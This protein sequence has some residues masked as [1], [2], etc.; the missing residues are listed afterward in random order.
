VALGV[1]LGRREEWCAVKSADLNG[2]RLYFL[3]HLDLFGRREGVYGPTPA[4]GYEDNARRFALLS[5]G[6]LQLALALELRP[7]I[8]HAHDWQA[9]IVPAMVELIYRP[10]G[11]F[12]TARTVFSIHN[13]G[14]QG[15]FG[16]NEY[17]TL[18]FAADHRFQTGLEAQAGINFM[19]SAVS[20]AQKIVTVSPRYAREIQQ[21]RFG[22]GLHRE[23]Q[24]RASD[25]IGIINGVDVAEW[26]PKVDPHITAPYSATELAGKRQNKRAL[27]REFGL[28]ERPEVPLIGM[29]TRLVEQKGVRQLFAPGYG[30]MDRILDTL[31]VQV[32]VMGSG[33][34]WVERAVSRLA[35]RSPQFAAHIGYDTGLAHRVE[36]GSDF[37]L[38]PSVYEPCGLNQMYS[39]VYG[40]L[41]IVTR[42]GGLADTVDRETG[43]FIERSVPEDV[44][45]AVQTAVNAYRAE[46][47]R[48]DLMRREAMSRD[49]S[50]RR[51]AEEY[52]AVYECAVRIE[53]VF[54]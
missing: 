7:D 22:F 1:P 18:G 14:Y 37:F 28:A 53:R 19:R 46:P 13:F 41:P 42:T 51:A 2:V 36:A 48:I 20:H 31:D 10:R 54:A 43:F 45:H 5:R 6:A 26:D 47:E 35:E 27:Q 16:A 52:D 23:I 50:L 25:V 12:Q 39:M 15:E 44:F 33:L 30:A 17:D 29:V 9:G 3:E 24:A 38:M 34:G 32:V 21:P 11:M 40:T 49:F 4:M 8:I